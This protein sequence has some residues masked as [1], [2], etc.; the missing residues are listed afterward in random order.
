MAALQLGSWVE[1]ANPAGAAPGQVQS[2]VEINRWI[3]V[4]LGV[5]AAIALMQL[6]LEIRRLWIARRRAGDVG[7][8]AT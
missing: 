3:G 6:V 5:A 8:R 1:L 2:V 4:A 7:S